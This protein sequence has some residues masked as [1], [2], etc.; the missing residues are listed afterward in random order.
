MIRYEIEKG[1]FNGDYEVKDLPQ[2]W[3]D[4]Y[5]EYLGVRPAK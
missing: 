3:N 2:I 1:L 5:E 4:K